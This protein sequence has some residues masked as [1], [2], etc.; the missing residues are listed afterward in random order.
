[1]LVAVACT[2]R[3]SGSAGGESA[4]GVEQASIRASASSAS[5]EYHRIGSTQRIK[6]RVWLPS[7]CVVAI[8]VSLVSFLLCKW[9]DDR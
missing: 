8:D 4:G 6:V 2:A 5:S 7:I 9:K 3:G 1:V